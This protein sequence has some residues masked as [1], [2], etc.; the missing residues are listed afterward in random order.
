MGILKAHRRFVIVFL[1]I[2]I[3]LVVVALLG[4]TIVNLF[5]T[6]QSAPSQDSNFGLQIINNHTYW[7]AIVGKEFVYVDA[8]T[9]PGG[10]TWSPSVDYG[11]KQ[12]PLSALYTLG[13]LMGIVFGLSTRQFIT[14]KTTKATGRKL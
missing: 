13:I 7:A 10:S 4:P 3:C 8:E 14:W 1:A 2:A 12:L 9:L 5:T 6:D 11:P